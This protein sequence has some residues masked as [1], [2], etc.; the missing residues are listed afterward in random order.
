M[1][2][3]IHCTIDPG[4]YQATE[5]SQRLVNAL[6][7]PVLAL[8]ESGATLPEGTTIDDWS[9]K[10]GDT[11]TW[12]PETVSTLIDAN[13]EDNIPE[14]KVRF[15]C[16]TFS[17]SKEELLAM[18]DN[19]RERLDSGIWFCGK[20]AYMRAAYLWEEE[21]AD[22]L[23]FSIARFRYDNDGF[24]MISW[25]VIM[26]LFPKTV[27]LVNEVEMDFELTEEQLRQF[28]PLHNTMMS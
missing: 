4:R 24:L 26:S 12:S 13:A 18:G 22:P 7:R 19:V 5:T 1:K 14:G 20:M 6:Y 23:F 2:T 8:K 3:K 27:E 9:F 15:C 16:V 17:P 21:D 10:A 28:I 25:S 11:K